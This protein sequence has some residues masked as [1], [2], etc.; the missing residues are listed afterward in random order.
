[1]S[2][3][4]L[5]VIFTHPFSGETLTLTLPDSMRFKEVT[6]LLYENGFL[7]KKK[8]DYQYIVDGHLCNIAQ[9]LASYAYTGDE[10]K[11][12]IHGLLTIL[13]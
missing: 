9:Q 2:E 8:G 6:G 13:A 12:Q 1:M 4:I 7:K 10:L 11:V 5:N 3:R